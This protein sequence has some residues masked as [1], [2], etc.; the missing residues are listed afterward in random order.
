MKRW[1]IYLDIIMELL[2][3]FVG[4]FLLIV[5]IPKCLGFLWPF[6]ADGLF[7]EFQDR[8]LSIWRKR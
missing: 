7:Q 1:E 2:V 3:L 5:G 6:V 4:A 8:L